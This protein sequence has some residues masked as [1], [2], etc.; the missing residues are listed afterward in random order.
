MS[1]GA[2]MATGSVGR[3]LDPGSGGGPR[4]GAVGAFDGVLDPGA[5]RGA[6]GDFSAAGGAAC[7]AAAS[8]S[9]RAW[10]SASHP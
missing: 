6:G 4:R 3:E 5:T 9:D 10:A 2:R 7:V 1:I 8:F